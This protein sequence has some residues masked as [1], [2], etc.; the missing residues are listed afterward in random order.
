MGANLHCNTLQPS[1]VPPPL[2]HTLQASAVPTP[3]NSNQTTHVI[4]LRRTTLCGTLD[5]LPPEMVEGR[6][7]TAAVDN[8]SLGVLAYE[9]LFGGPPFEAP[10]H[11][12]TYRRIVRVD[13]KF[14]ESPA[15]S[16]EAKDF[17]TKV[18]LGAR[19]RHARGLHLRVG[20]LGLREPP[21]LVPFKALGVKAW[22]SLVSQSESTRL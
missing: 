18:R 6:E 14:P 4:S 17:I 21:D 5:Y 19:V 15:V 13:L 1:A 3:L 2:T 8:W 12:E 11:Q 16:E 22:C 10:G 7:H 9:F 20:G